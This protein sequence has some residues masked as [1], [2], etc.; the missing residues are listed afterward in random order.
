MCVICRY[1]S[2]A[3]STQGTPGAT[4]ALI[5]LLDLVDKYW[6][7]SKSLHD[8]KKFMSKQSM[9]LLVCCAVCLISCMCVWKNLAGIFA[10]LLTECVIIYDKCSKL[11]Q[12]FL[13]FSCNFS[14]FWLISNL[15]VQMIT[16]LFQYAR[17]WSYIP[18]NTIKFG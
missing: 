14:I 16:R 1:S 9:L 17:H 13:P 10:M 12:S 11:K 5:K 3:S 6:N 18:K 7:G 2:G 8:N 4:P 15:S